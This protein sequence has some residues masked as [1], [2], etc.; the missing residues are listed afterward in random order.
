MSYL[1]FLAAQFGTLAVIALVLFV[2]GV[3]ED[4]R[5]DDRSCNSD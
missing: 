3:V 4:R 2:C 5:H 1:V